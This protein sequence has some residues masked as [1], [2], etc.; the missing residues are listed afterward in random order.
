MTTAANK[1]DFVPPAQTQTRVPANELLNSANAGVTII[2]SGQIKNLF[3]HE[4][5]VFARDVSDYINAKQ[6]GVATVFNF[7]ETFGTQDHIYWLIHMHSL[8]DYVDLLKMGK[9]DEAFQE[10]FTRER[11]SADKGG[12]KWD[13]MFVDA[14][15]HETVLTAHHWGSHGTDKPSGEK[16]QVL[17]PAQHQTSLKPHEV[18]HSGNAGAILVRSGQVKHE[19]RSEARQFARDVIDHINKAQT[20][21]ATTLVYEEHFGV[22]DRIYWLTHMRTL[23]D[24]HTICEMGT[25]DDAFRSIFTKQRVRDGGDWSRIFIDASLEERLLMPQHPLKGC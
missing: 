7:E 15:F 20:G 16:G 9:E 17:K 19:F 11:V 12:G 10:I 13:M 2:R 3:R 18:F 5:R 23:G 22:Q 6:V 25:N 21:L 14:S 8:D 4:A 24:Y 1:W